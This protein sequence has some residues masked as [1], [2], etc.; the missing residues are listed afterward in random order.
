[1]GLAAFLCV[2]FPW[3]TASTPFTNAK[4]MPALLLDG[5]GRVGARQLAPGDWEA[6]F[7]SGRT[8]QHTDR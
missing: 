2:V 8:G 5:G 6:R 4:M 7:L 1:M 3:S